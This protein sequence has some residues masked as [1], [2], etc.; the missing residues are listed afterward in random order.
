[1]HCVIPLIRVFLIEFPPNA[2][3]KQAL[4]EASLLFQ[5]I[6]TYLAFVME[7]EVRNALLTRLQKDDWSEASVDS[8][9]GFLS[10]LFLVSY[11]LQEMSASGLLS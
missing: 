9:E 4:T 6:T 7:D 8:S 2:T 11:K 5:S 3:Y 1:M 10:R